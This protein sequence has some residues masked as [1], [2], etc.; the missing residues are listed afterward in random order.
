MQDWYLCDHPLI[1]IWAVVSA[2]PVSVLVD[3]DESFEF[4]LHTHNMRGGNVGVFIHTHIF[5][6]GAGLGT[7]INAHLGIPDNFYDVIETHCGQSIY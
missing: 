5:T 2:I 4:S 6:Y 3:I 1:L 7:P